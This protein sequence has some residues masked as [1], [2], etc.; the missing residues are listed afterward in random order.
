MGLTTNSTLRLN[1]LWVVTEVETLIFYSFFRVIEE[2]R[3]GSISVGIFML[4]DRITV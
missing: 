2:N 3:H 1:Q 4:S